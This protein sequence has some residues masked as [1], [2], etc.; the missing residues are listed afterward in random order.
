M[1][2]IISGAISAGFYFLGGNA[3]EPISASVSSDDLDRELMGCLKT[4]GWPEASAQAVVKLNLDRY[5]WLRESADAVL[6]REFEKFKWLRPGGRVS[7]LLEKHPEMAGVLLLVSEPA[8]VASGILDCDDAEDR[9]QLIGSFVKYTEAREISEWAAA[10]ARHG[11]CIAGLLRRC[12]A[13]PVDAVFMFPKSDEAATDE[14]SRWLDDILDPAAL[15]QSDD[16]TLSLVEFVLAAGPEVR[17]R[18][19]KDARFRDS[20]RGTIWPAFARCV[21]RFSDERGGRCAWEIF[22]DSPQVWDLMM[23]SDG[24][25]LFQRAGFLAVDLLYGEGAVVTELREKAAQ[26]LLLGNQEFVERAFDGPWGHHPLFRKLMLERR[27]SDEQLLSACNKLAGA[28]D[29]DAVLDGWNGMSDAALVADVGPPPEGFVTI[30][31]GYAVFYAAKKMVQGRGV[32]WMDAV[33]IA[34]DVASF[35]SMGAGKVATEALKQA[36]KGASKEAVK[37]LVK[38]KFR[39]EA[40]KDI[41]QLAGREL[42]EQAEKQA[43]SFVAHHAMRTL[44]DELKERFLKSFVVEVTPLVH[45]CFKIA[46]KFGLGRESF[47]KITQLE[48]RIF[49]RKDAK[50][51][52]SLASALAGNNP[53]ARFLNATAING[54]VDA[55]VRTKPAQEAARATI[56]FA[57]DE[58]VRLRQNLAC[59]WSGLATGAF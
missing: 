21:R 16:E 43:V 31:P 9:V 10:V 41:A 55:A 34:G 14:Y 17:G 50:V 30:V 35:V 19:A 6:E 44:P 46:G 57:S 49:M 27:L 26:L 58:S 40:V 18:M 59:W 47:K 48:A 42:E 1:T 2:L 28:G 33:G 15:P 22:A 11:R 7:A 51:Y 39:K 45:G 8:A 20:F 38:Q 29:P 32:D 4:H 56:R 24:E 53:S 5:V 52:V 37:A 13:W 36:G 23:R 25:A 54:A 3:V 12:P